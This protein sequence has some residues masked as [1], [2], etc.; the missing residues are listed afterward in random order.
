MSRNDE[1]RALIRELGELTVLD[2]QSPQSFR[3]RAYG[4]AVPALETLSIDIAEMTSEALEAL[5]GIGK[6]TA[7]KIRVYV[8][9]GSIPKLEALRL[10][11]PPDVVQLSRIPG[12]GPKTL[13]K[14]RAEL[15]I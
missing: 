15:D 7:S 5:P 12:L 3:A 9:T 6:A 1:I 11:F 4:R 14:L 8:E 13:A 2:E 10:K